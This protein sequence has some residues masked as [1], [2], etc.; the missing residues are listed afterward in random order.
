MLRETRWGPK[1]YESVV[2]DAIAIFDSGKVGIFGAR[3][4]SF[5]ILIESKALEKT[6]Q[7]LFELLWEKSTPAK[8]GEG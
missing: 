2:D 7:M 3:E 5:G 1:K 8:P 4:E 6:M